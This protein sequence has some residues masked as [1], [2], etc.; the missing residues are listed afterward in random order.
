MAEAARGRDSTKDA[1]ARAQNDFT[2]IILADA[3]RSREQLEFLFG[4][5]THGIGSGK[6]FRLTDEYAGRL[7]I[8]RRHAISVQGGVLGHW[9]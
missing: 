1:L 8:A 2:E 5:P 7:S 6:K 3:P 9:P 4:D